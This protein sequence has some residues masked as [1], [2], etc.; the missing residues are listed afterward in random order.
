[1]INTKRLQDLNVDLW[2]IFQQ[3]FPSTREINDFEMN[4]LKIKMCIFCLHPHMANYYRRLACNC[5]RWLWSKYKASYRR[6]GDP[7]T[8]KKSSVMS[9]WKVYH[10]TS[11]PPNWRLTFPWQL[12]KRFWLMD[13]W[14]T[15][16]ERKSGCHLCSVSPGGQVAIGSEAAISKDAIINGPCTRL[17]NCFS[18]PLLSSGH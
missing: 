17:W 2:C 12:C 18:L 14:E 16:M 8:K 5:K 9:S 13:F 10:L 3:F 1:M 15:W 6:A 11:T 7:I 4:N